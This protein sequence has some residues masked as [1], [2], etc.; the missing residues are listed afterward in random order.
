MTK[1]R[2]LPP[3]DD[4][5]E[6]GPVQFGDDW[7]GVFIRGDN[8]AMYAFSLQSLL[9]GHDDPIAAAVVEGLVQTLTSSRVHRGNQTDFVEIVND[10]N[11]CPNCG[12]PADNG[13]DRSYPPAPY[14][15]TKCMESR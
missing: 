13:H 4:R 7:P 2:H 6:T 3:V 10:L 15:C 5:V 8:A 1:I 14:F 12:G 11:I 9:D